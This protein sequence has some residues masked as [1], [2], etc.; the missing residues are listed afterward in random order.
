MTSHGQRGG[1]RSGHQGPACVFAFDMSPTRA[2]VIFVK[3]TS[4]V[5][6][7]AFVT[8]MGLSDDIQQ[9]CSELSCT[10]KLGLNSMAMAVIQGMMRIF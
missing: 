1:Q 4:T 10:A 2:T 9:W 8:L 6:R 7:Y 3:S 5:A